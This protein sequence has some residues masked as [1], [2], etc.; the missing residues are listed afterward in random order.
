MRKKRFGYFKLERYKQHLLL[1]E[2]YDIKTKG[3][4]VMARKI[5]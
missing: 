1:I 5:A 2:F 4:T 3:I